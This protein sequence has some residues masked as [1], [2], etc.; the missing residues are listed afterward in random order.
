M[1]V[2]W[3]GDN[4]TGF[5][6]E[7]Q[8]DAWDRH[9]LLEDLSRTF[10][11]AGINIVEAR[12]LVQH[13]MTRNRFVIEVGPLARRHPGAEGRDQPPARDRQRLRR[14][15]RHPSR[16]IAR[17]AASTRS[18]PRARGH[19]RGQPA[20]RPRRPARRVARSRRG[21]GRRGRRRQLGQHPAARRARRLPTGGLV[22]AERGLRG[23]AGPGADTRARPRPVRSRGDARR[24]VAI[25]DT[26]PT[27][28]SRRGGLVARSGGLPRDGLG[29]ADLR[30]RAD[31]HAQ[32]L[33]AAP[34]PVAAARG[35]AAA[36]SSASTRRARSAPPR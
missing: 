17:V 30:A 23:A 9:R 36:A 27:R 20:R 4:E 6:V 3:D 16:G 33:P 35:R 26:E 8:V 32:R 18:R 5:K 29:A 31:R 2:S 10:A 34:R 28:T 13:P 19:A 22:R 24:P 15:P 11:E 12:C 25:P 21:R 14:L 7:I 1:P